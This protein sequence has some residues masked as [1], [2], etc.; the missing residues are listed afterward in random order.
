[1]KKIFKS[2]KLIMVGLFSLVAVAVVSVGAVTLS[3][4]KTGNYIDEGAVVPT[5]SSTMAEDGHLYDKYLRLIRAGADAGEG[6][7]VVEFETLGGSDQ[8]LDAPEEESDDLFTINCDFL[9]V[10]ADGKPILGIDDYIGTSGY[11]SELGN[12]Y[13]SE[14][15]NSPKEFTIGVD[16]NFNEAGG[17]YIN[18]QLVPRTGEGYDTLSNSTYYNFNTANTYYISAI[19]YYI[20]GESGTYSAVSTI[21][22]SCTYGEISYSGSNLVKTG[23]SYTTS[24]NGFEFGFTLDPETG[25][26]D[27]KITTIGDSDSA[28]LLN[29]NIKVACQVKL[30]DNNSYKNSLEVIDTALTENSKVQYNI[31]EGSYTPISINNPN[32]ISSN[33]QNLYTTDDK[34]SVTIDLASNK[35]VDA[36][37]VGSFTKFGGTKS[38][39][40]WFD[41]Y[42]GVMVGKNGEFYYF[43]NDEITSKLIDAGFLVEDSISFGSLDA[44]GN[45]INQTMSVTKMNRSKYS[46]KTIIVVEENKSLILTNGYNQVLYIEY[47]EEFRNL[48][49][50]NISTGKSIV[51]DTVSD[52]TGGGTITQAKKFTISEPNNQYT[53]FTLYF[54]NSGKIVFE[55]I[56]LEKSTYINVTEQDYYLVLFEM[57]SGGKY[58]SGAPFDD[59]KLGITT[60]GQAGGSE[61][62]FNYIFSR[63]YNTT[64]FED[65]EKLD[66]QQFFAGVGVGSTISLEVLL[67]PN[68]LY[69]A[70]VDVNYIQGVKIE[71]IDDELKIKYLESG[72][73]GGTR[74]II[75]HKN[76]ENYDNY[77]L[78]IKVVIEGENR[79]FGLSGLQIQTGGSSYIVDTA[80]GEKTLQSTYIVSKVSSSSSRSYAV[81]K[82]DGARPRIETWYSVALPSGYV[83]TRL[84]YNYAD[85]QG[86]SGEM[87]IGGYSVESTDTGVYVLETAEDGMTIYG[88]L[89]LVFYVKAVEVIVPVYVEYDA[90]LYGDTFTYTDDLVNAIIYN[91]A[92]MNETELK[93]GTSASGLYKLAGFMKVSVVTDVKAG[94]LMT[95]RIEVSFAKYG[96]NDYIV[97]DLNNLVEK[98]GYA[99]LGMYSSLDG[100]SD[101]AYAG[102]G[103]MGNTNHDGLIYDNLI[104]TGGVRFVDGR[105]DNIALLDANYYQILIDGQYFS[106]TTYIRY[107]E[108]YKRENVWDSK[109]NIYFKEVSTFTEGVYYCNAQG[110]IITYSADW[111]D[112][113]RSEYKYM[114][115]LKTRSSLVENHTYYDALGVSSIYNSDTCGESWKNRFLYE[116]KNL[117]QE[118]SFVRQNSKND[119]F[120]ELN[121]TYKVSTVDGDVYYQR[122]MTYEEAI[123]LGL[124]EEWQRVF[125]NTFIKVSSTYSS[126]LY[127]NAEGKISTTF[128]SGNFMYVLSGGTGANV[129]STAFVDA[130]FMYLNKLYAYMY[131]S[132]ENDANPLVFYGLFDSVSNEKEVIVRDYNY[133]YSAGDGISAPKE[134]YIVATGYIYSDTDLVVLEK[135]AYEK[136]L[137]IDEATGISY[138]VPTSVAYSSLTRIDYGAYPIDCATYALEQYPVDSPEYITVGQRLYYFSTSSD[139]LNKAISDENITGT[140]YMVNESNYKADLKRVEDKVVYHLASIYQ[141][142]GLNTTLYVRPTSVDYN[143]TV[144]TINAE[145]RVQTESELTGAV[146]YSD[147][148]LYSIKTFYDIKF[149]T[150]NIKLRTS[151]YYS[152]LPSIE[153]NKGNFINGVLGTDE[154]RDEA[155]NAFLLRGYRLVGLMPFTTT[156][157]L[158]SNI[159][160]NARYIDLEFL[161][162][163]F[164]YTDSDIYNLKQEIVA[165]MSTDD[166]EGRALYTKVVGRAFDRLSVEENKIFVNAI[167]DYFNI[168]YTNV[169]REMCLKAFTDDTILSG[170]EYVPASSSYDPIYAI[171]KNKS[172]LEQLVGEEVCENFLKAE[173]F[174]VTKNYNSSIWNNVTNII[175]T[176][177]INNVTYNYFRDVVF[178]PVFETADPTLNLDA[179]GDLRIDGVPIDAGGKTIDGYYGYNIN[180]IYDDTG[181][182]P[183]EIGETKTPIYSIQFNNMYLKTPDDNL[184][185]Y[186]ENATS[187]ISSRVRI[188]ERVMASDVNSIFWAPPYIPNGY[189]ISGYYLVDAMAG[190]RIKVVDVNYTI[191]RTTRTVKFTASLDSTMFTTDA[192][193]YV[194]VKEGSGGM[195]ITNF[196]YVSEDGKVYWDLVNVSN[197]PLM[198]E[199]EYEPWPYTI[200]FSAEDPESTEDNIIEEDISGV[201]IDITNDFSGE[202]VQD[203]SIQDFLANTDGIYKN[204]TMYVFNTIKFNQLA[205][206]DSSKLGAGKYI[207]NGVFVSA[208][209][210]TY[211]TIFDGSTKQWS[212]GVLFEIKTDTKGLPYVASK[213]I[214]K[215]EVGEGNVTRTLE[216]ITLDNVGEG[217]YDALNYDFDNDCFVFDV[218]ALVNAENAVQDINFK[219]IYDYKT[220][221]LSFNAGLYHNTSFESE[222][223]ILPLDESSY[224]TNYYLINYST[225]TDPNTWILCDEFGVPTGDILGFQDIEFLNNETILTFGTDTFERL[226]TLEAYYN[227]KIKFFAYWVR[228]IRGLGVKT[229][230]GED[231][232]YE[233]MDIY[234][235]IGVDAEGTEIWAIPNI[236]DSESGGSFDYYTLF[237]DEADINVHY[238]VWNPLVGE[239]GTNGY[240]ATAHKGYFWGKETLSKSFNTVN[241]YEQYALSRDAL[242]TYYIVGWLKVYDNINTKVG[243]LPEGGTGLVLDEYKHSYFTLDENQKYLIVE[244]DTY[245]YILGLGT[246][247]YCPAGGTGAV[248]VTYS[249][250]QTVSVPK[251]NTVDENLGPINIYMYAIYAKVEYSVSETTDPDTSEVSYTPV[252]NVPNTVEGMVNGYQFNELDLTSPDVKNKSNVT[253]YWAKITQDDYESVY[254]KYISIK[255]MLNSGEL[256]FKILTGADGT[257]ISGAITKTDVLDQLSAREILVSF[258]IRGQSILKEDIV[259]SGG[260]DINGENQDIIAGAKLVGTRTSDDFKYDEFEDINMNADGTLVGVLDDKISLNGEYLLMYTKSVELLKPLKG[261]NLEEFQKRELIIRT[262]LQIAQWDNVYNSQ[263]GSIQ[264]SNG[265]IYS[266]SATINLNNI[267]SYIKIL[268]GEASENLIRLNNAGFV[269][270][271]YGI[272]S[273]S[274]VSVY[275][276]VALED[277]FTFTTS[278]GSKSI[279]EMTSVIDIAE[280]ASKTIA[281]DE[282]KIGDIILCATIDEETGD[283]SYHIAIFAGMNVNEYTNVVYIID[284]RNATDTITIPTSAKTA[285][286][287]AEN[288][289]IIFNASLTPDKYTLY[290]GAN[291]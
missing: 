273:A 179:K 21:L 240:F 154:L 254:A 271:V 81:E 165:K 103:H 44:E 152:Y 204:G 60:S 215:V 231:A 211:T 148:G 18:F 237:M 242:N 233:E 200:T 276:E 130:S 185:K 187:L 92:I 234:D 277:V 83:F 126:T 206:K 121:L 219:F 45:Y 202:A 80:T 95:K 164:G 46:Y 122:Y 214:V 241:A 247:V 26:L 104:A 159:G 85:V 171:N 57:Y 150:P 291:Y 168:G 84:A 17:K 61:Q 230:S 272:A 244:Y 173:R 22:G 56:D 232:T 25:M 255:D 138:F 15:K 151:G 197:N 157:L 227:G 98:Y 100:L 239:T 31:S 259:A 253:L 279:F 135:L 105:T 162:E 53:K 153:P 158:N 141:D 284:C 262:A 226:N 72:I 35:I 270:L 16:D 275:N 38:Y 63:E 186:Y 188:N 12:A 166:E 91:K 86:A 39:T 14:I 36:L 99:F 263:G 169:T 118:Y 278:F 88:N 52:Y 199:A 34:I 184:N 13:Y 115:N 207:S 3:K 194:V 210:I 212:L 269:S 6:T 196:F 120:F 203:T 33:P 189:Y 287:D 174:V 9:T 145:R 65:G 243:I 249:M 235:K 238:Y 11:V 133:D 209:E 143:M 66:P 42:G 223:Q 8:A 195:N 193:G 163:Y 264:A 267:N 102:I 228:D 290:L 75:A 55:K 113:Q 176:N 23:Y 208:I 216:E 93:I 221:V 251:R 119:G 4:L 183:V 229:E 101:G 67:D 54:Y 167:A 87:G 213:Q 268:R 89:E 77:I 69:N 109:F 274:F 170:V 70:E 74:D 289:T 41:I 43:F 182:E 97:L 111:T 180:K 155:V 47:T 136:Q 29:S 7:H 96:T 224:T 220:Y 260:I 106:Y 142:N 48:N 73:A 50:G 198:F 79:A 20:S 125:N 281:K 110:E 218:E 71:G 68:Y 205:V 78:Q 132:G 30:R 27:F 124:E 175:T 283:T 127:V 112:T 128:E 252:A 139:A 24:T 131:T 146:V 37:S 285:T 266:D 286:F 107:I 147:T 250:N 161:V 245:N 129:Y 134:I 137:W 82:V 236:F 201:K 160:D 1:M 282:L 288:S 51:F 28:R 190:T 59:I 261:S 40:K 191:D 94:G 108:D 62:Q 156:K 265:I 246:S 90:N 140:K 177:N 5:N 58:L 114:L 19:T 49:A 248:L 192:N 10:G 117:T 256:P 123:G 144:V 32:P 280:N 172:I 258:Y 257:P 225:R 149:G 64:H 222:G 217:I 76:S 2:T 178:I 116:L 181:E